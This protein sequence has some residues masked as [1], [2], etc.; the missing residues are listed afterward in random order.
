MRYLP[1]SGC[2]VPRLYSPEAGPCSCGARGFD[3][4]TVVAMAGS[5][6]LTAAPSATLRERRDWHVRW[7]E[8]LA[9]FERARSPRTV[10]ISAESIRSARREVLDLLVP[11]WHFREV[12][13]AERIP[14]LSKS[15]IDQFAHG[16][17]ALLLV[18]DLCNT[19]KHVDT[20][21]PPP[22]KN[23]GKQKGHGPKSGPTYPT[24]KEPTAKG[25]A[26][27]EQGWVIALPV[28]SS[29]TTRDVLDVV[30][31]A[32]AAW[33]AQLKSWNLV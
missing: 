21:L 26:P 7:G 2:K 17:S 23:P 19:E 33:R 5:S 32:I 4:D 14:G 31:D 10:T 22:P 27:P 18:A 12:L 24:L 25:L 1:C 29:T 30:G 20:A 13:I 16:C 3:G 11:I 9:A 15:Q 6:K 8:I 28:E